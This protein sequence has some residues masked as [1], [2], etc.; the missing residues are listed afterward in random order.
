MNKGKIITYWVLIVLTML[1]VL[2]TYT[3]TGIDISSYSKYFLSMATPVLFIVFL[4]ICFLLV[5]LSYIVPKALAKKNLL[6]VSFFLE[7]ILL[8][9]S[10]ALSIRI[11]MKGWLS[12]SA[13]ATVVLLFLLIIVTI[14]ML[15][16]LYQ[17][18][19]ELVS[20]K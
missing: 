12:I 3:V 13:I 7:V 4:M 11:Y 20:K 10:I 9:I 2:Y 5:T 17:L 8:I 15:K 1:S 6:R 18:V 16:E 14:L 19:R